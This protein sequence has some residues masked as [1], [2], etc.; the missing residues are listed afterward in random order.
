MGEWG[1]P[2]GEESGKLEGDGAA[3]AASRSKYYIQVRSSDRVMDCKWGPLDEVGDG[4][5]GE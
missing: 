3:G 5:N 1:E 4:Q 2:G